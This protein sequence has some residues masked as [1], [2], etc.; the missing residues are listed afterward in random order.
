MNINFLLILLV[1]FFLVDRMSCFC[2]FSSPSLSS[3]FPTLLLRRSVR[4]ST[5]AGQLL[6][7]STE[8][9]NKISN[10][11]TLAPGSHQSEMEVKKSRFIGYA[12]H[13]ETW[14]E[15][16]AYI[17]QV[18]MEH[19]K[20]RHWCVGFRCGVN[21][22]SERCNDDGEPQG[23]AGLPILGAIRGEDLSD[24]VCVVVR[25]FGK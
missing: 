13:V 5:G 12:Q 19:P 10:H 14:P 25:Y 4:P 15:A 9:E 23:T 18:K 17:E 1:A 22:V 7:M 24:V 6:F 3:S 21:P 11:R 20:A 8:E 16:Q 2:S